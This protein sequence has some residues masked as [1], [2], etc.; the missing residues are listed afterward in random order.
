MPEA[1]RAAAQEQIDENQRALD[2]AREELEAGAADLD[3][4]R[5]FIALVDD[6]ATISQ[7]G[8]SAVGVVMFTTP[9]EELSTE[10]KQEVVDRLE[11]AG[12]PGVE[13]QPTLTL[14]Q[15]V[16]QLMGPGEVVGLAIA[17]VALL[18]V[19]RT[20]VGSVLPLITA[21]TG[22]GVGITGSL[23]FSGVVDM[24]AVTPI[25]GIMLGLAVGIDYAL[26]IINRHRHQLKEGM[27]VDRA[28]GVAA[29]TSGN[30]VLFAGIT[31]VIALAALNATGVPFLALMGTVAAACV[32]VAVLVALTLTPALL[33][34]AGL[35]VLT[36]KERAEL[37]TLD[38]AG[39]AAG[40]EARESEGAHAVEPAGSNA[41]SV[42][43][44]ILVPL[45]LV[46]LATP[47]LSMRLGLPDGLSEP[48]GSGA[49]LAYQTLTEGF[50]E[51]HNGPLVATIDLPAGLDDQGVMEQQ[52][53]VG[54]Q[55]RALPNVAA[56]LPTAV[57]DDRGLA[58]FQII[59]TEGPNAESTKALVERLRTTEPEGEST[60]LAVAGATSGAI[61]VADKL[62]NA[63][64]LYLTIVVLLSL[65]IL[66]VVLRSLLLPLIASV[67]FV[68]SVFAA[69]GGVI[70]IYQWGWL[71]EVFSVAH[72]APLAPF[73]PTIMI[74]VLFGLAMDYQLFISSGMREAYAHGVPARAAVSRGL[75]LGRSVVIAAAIIMIAV[76][77]GFI[78]SDSAMIRPMGFGLAFGVLLDAFLVRLLLVPAL[79]H[80][81]G[82]AVWWL[83]RWLDRLLPDVDVE[84]STLPQQEVGAVSERAAP[85][86]AR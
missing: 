30:A 4:G 27:P 18:A 47:F 19:L 56:V 50:G 6:Y 22:V 45:L 84:G 24:V 36:R 51:G 37:A 49:N 28:A 48:E 41:R 80:L 11:D 26:F 58:M 2:A 64:P 16:P 83:P 81:L 60:N 79:M 35:R 69:M 38:V 75:R 78:F 42:L 77:G 72:P 61:D 21:L 40:G 8:A 9:G 59:P 17:A 71:A 67:G 70:A 66:T 82:P 33:G 13:I 29:A 3:R 20:A 55:L 44:C 1:Q 63:L 76:F 12:I 74:G 43:A 46:V 39:P 14:V 31:V 15:A 5:R 32:T 53:T 54:E 73:V 62:M 10:A 65:V 57:S 85:G 7:D 23:A 25:L 86:T 52:V 68:L 34:L